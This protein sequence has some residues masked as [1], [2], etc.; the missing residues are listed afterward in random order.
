MSVL[1]RVFWHDH[2]HMFLSRPPK[3]AISTVM[4]RLN[5]PKDKHVLLTRSCLPEGKRVA[6]GSLSVQPN[7]EEYYRGRLILWLGCLVPKWG[8]RASKLARSKRDLSCA[9]RVP[10]RASGTQYAKSRRP[11]TISSANDRAQVSAVIHVNV[12]N[13]AG[14]TIDCKADR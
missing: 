2:F 11:N 4:Q 7:S 1:S 14:E 9:H 13:D 5:P 6:F 10:R 12:N 3:P 8:Q